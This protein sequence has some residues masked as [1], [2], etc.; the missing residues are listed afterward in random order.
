M[1]RLAKG[2]D[3]TSFLADP[4]HGVFFLGSRQGALACYDLPSSRLMGVWR[5]IHGEESV[6]S[7]RLHGIQ[8]DQYSTEIMTTGRDS[9]F[10]ILK[11]TVPD[12]LEGE[13]P[14]DVVDGYLAGVRMQI[15]HRSLLH[16]GWLEGV[17]SSFK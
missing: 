11:I 7:I 12:V 17:S 1:I 6:R 9:V 10:K 14:L 8:K 3:V 16:R 13:L 5:R 2:F 15:V 4:D